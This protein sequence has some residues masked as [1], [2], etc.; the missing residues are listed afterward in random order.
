MGDLYPK[1]QNT[2]TRSEETPKL[3]EKQTRELEDAAVLYLRTRRISIDRP[4]VLRGAYDVLGD[5][6]R[7]QLHQEGRMLS[8]HE[9]L[10]PLI[11]QGLEQRNVVRHTA[12]RIITFTRKQ[13]SPYQSRTV[14]WIGPLAIDRQEVI[15]M[16]RMLDEQ[17]FALTGEIT[18]IEQF[19]QTYAL[20]SELVHLLAKRVLGYLPQAVGIISL[21]RF[22]YLEDQV[23]LLRN[24]IANYAIQR[25]V[26]PLLLLDDIIPFIANDDAMDS[27]FG[28]D[29]MQEV[30]A[31]IA[32]DGIDDRA[33]VEALCMQV[34]DIF[35][36]NRAQLSSKDRESLFAFLSRDLSILNPI[37]EEGILV[38]YPKNVTETNLGIWETAA[39]IQGVRIPPPLALLHAANRMR[40]IG[41]K[42]ETLRLEA[43]LHAWRKYRGARSEGKQEMKLSKQSAVLRNHLRRVSS[44]SFTPPIIRGVIRGNEHTLTEREMM[45]RAALLW[46]RIEKAKVYQAWLGKYTGKGALPMLPDPTRTIP[47][48]PSFTEEALLSKEPFPRLQNEIQYIKEYIEAA[49]FL[50]WNCALADPKIYPPGYF[51]TM[52]QRKDGDV[53]ILQEIEHMQARTRSYHPVVLSNEMLQ[54]VWVEFNAWYEATPEAMK[55]YIEEDEFLLSIKSELLYQAGI[56]QDRRLAIDR[57]LTH[58]Q[59]VFL[60]SR[61]ALFE[62]AGRFVFDYNRKTGRETALKR[63]WR[64]SMWEAPQVH[65]YLRKISFLNIEGISKEALE[66]NQPFSLGAM[67]E[68]LTHVFSPAANLYVFSVDDLKAQVDKQIQDLDHQAYIAPTRRNV[69]FEHVLSTT[70]ARWA[71]KSAQYQLFRKCLD[72]PVC[73]VP[74]QVGMVMS[75]FVQVCIDRID[76]LLASQGKGISEQD[77][78]QVLQVCSDTLKK[79]F[80]DVLQYR[81]QT[82]DE[83]LQTKESSTVVEERFVHEMD[84]LQLVLR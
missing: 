70:G 39:V 3:G 47:A 52:S 5:A 69:D 63:R 61:K 74:G 72:H 64:R 37:F 16:E 57:R 4:S 9:K 29:R 32:G 14:R 23:K 73:H 65:T 82:L 35:L 11:E 44:E 10:R 76:L 1:P 67:R 22:P 60:R 77:R 84:T 75:E 48:D 38:L 8:S 19:I 6:V 81:V 42:R 83:L 46:E 49:D 36:A 7:R 79:I 25:S 62:Q 71:W 56:L 50:L 30:V 15:A 20:K 43:G 28:D 78:Q 18:P 21:D 68:F 45:Q 58:F 31:A 24:S 51:A 33:Y 54:R 53:T 26:S 27:G 2:D 80:V 17:T 12:N 55:A 40:A 41:N 13:Q 59:H 34:K 66:E